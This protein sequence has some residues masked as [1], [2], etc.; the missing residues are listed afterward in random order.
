MIYLVAITATLSAFLDN[1]TTVLLMIPV[2]LVT[3]WRRIASCLL[4]GFPLTLVAS[5]IASAYIL[6]FQL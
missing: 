2:T 3:A 4:W 6:L 1:V 5:F